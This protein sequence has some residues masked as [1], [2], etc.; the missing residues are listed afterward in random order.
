MST[1]RTRLFSG[2][3]HFLSGLCLVH[4]LAMPF[5]IVA[6]PSVSGFLQHDAEMIITFAVLPFSILGF[7]PTW[8]KHKNRFI[9][10]KFVAALVLFVL[11]NTVFHDVHG[12][13]E[14]T[15]TMVASMLTS[16]AN[17]GVLL[18]LSGALLMA[19]A[20]YRNNRHVHVCHN[21][22]HRH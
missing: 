22:L 4:C 5:L 14:S 1:T 18:S 7:I 2:L 16:A 8:W 20:M 3:T 19:Y 21:P 13:D 12:P 17:P 11:G 15:T 9:A 10:T 6:L